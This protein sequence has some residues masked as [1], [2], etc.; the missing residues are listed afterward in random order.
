M[1]CK[2]CLHE[3]ESRLSDQSG[4]SFCNNRILC[5]D[6][7]CKVCFNKSFASSKKAQYW[8]KENLTEPRKIFK[9]CN[10]KFL[11]FCN[12]C[13]HSFITSPNRIFSG[14]WCP[15]CNNKTELLVHNWL[16]K[17]F[18]SVD[19]KPQFTIHGC[20]NKTKL[21]FDFLIESLKIII[22]VDGLQHFEIIKNWKTCPV[23]A[24]QRDVYKMEC[25]QKENYKVIR[26]YQADI[27]KNP[28]YYMTILEDL[29]QNPKQLEQFTFISSN[30]KLYDNH[31]KELSKQHFVE[32]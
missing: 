2:D 27:W 19:V 16:I 1:K 18:G 6:D 5:E 11:F 10:K 4:C 26:M 31:K 14:K 15:F 7:D 28:D 23:K 25:A 32:V 24:L 21:R 9:N 13:S 29:L 12:E 3:Y 20:I 30:E 17:L 22:E 8:S